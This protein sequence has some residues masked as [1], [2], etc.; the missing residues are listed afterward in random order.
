M[1]SGRGKV[2]RPRS[3]EEERRA[4]VGIYTRARK[5]GCAKGRH[6]RTRSE[7]AQMRGYK[8]TENGDRASK[9]ERGLSAD[10]AA[11]L[12]TSIYVGP[13]LHLT[14]YE[15]MKWLNH[16]TTD[17]YNAID[18]LFIYYAGPLLCFCALPF[19]LPSSSF[20]VPPFSFSH[21]R[22]FSFSRSFFLMAGPV[23]CSRHV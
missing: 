7:R 6:D 19:P 23:L 22:F 11:N 1:G 16:F 21:L 14:L 2:E 18:S 4:T 8:K 17:V 13:R 10:T 15:P 3:S 9:G 5:G 20:L 12:T